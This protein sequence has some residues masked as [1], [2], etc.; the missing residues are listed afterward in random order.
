MNLC[1]ILDPQ[2]EICHQEAIIFFIVSRHDVR[3][4]LK[5]LSIQQ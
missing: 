3:F 5:F 2:M 4:I 1:T